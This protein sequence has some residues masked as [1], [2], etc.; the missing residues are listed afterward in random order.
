MK[1]KSFLFNSPPIAPLDIQKILTNS[2][3]LDLKSFH[4]IESGTYDEYG[5]EHETHIDEIQRILNAMKEKK[6]II[7]KNMESYNIQIMRAAKSLGEDTNVHM[8]LTPEGGESFPP[9]R[10]DRN[11]LIEMLWGKKDFLI[12]NEPMNDGTYAAL[13]PVSLEKGESLFLPRLYQHKAKP[14]TASCLLSFGVSTDIYDAHY[15]YGL[16]GLDTNVLQCYYND[17]ESL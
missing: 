2:R 9:H 16:Q 8:Y 5:V 6:T 17:K 10:D 3:L 11:V 7:V 1:M 14:I 15:S 4:V 13:N 12:Y